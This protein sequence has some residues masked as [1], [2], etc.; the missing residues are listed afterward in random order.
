MV[1]LERQ[2]LK[3]ILKTGYAGKELH[4]VYDTVI[5]RFR[6]TIV[7]PARWLFL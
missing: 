2:N 1:E 3:T 6:F 5:H 7:V 4:Q